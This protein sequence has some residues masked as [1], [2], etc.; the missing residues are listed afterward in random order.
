MNVR[1]AVNVLG[2]SSEACRSATAAG[3]RWQ[4]RAA[5]LGVAACVLLALVCG[6]C[7]GSTRTTR[8]G[9]SAADFN[10]QVLKAE[11]PILVQFSKDGCVACW[12]MDG[13]V[14][15]LAQEYEGR[16]TMASFRAYNFLFGIPCKEIN[17]RYNIGAVP[18]VILF[19]N[20]QEKKRWV[21]EHNG[22]KYRPV[23]DQYAGPV[24]TPKEVRAAPRGA[25]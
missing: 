17:R 13:L 3:R 22:D 19:I 6:G 11:K 9:E 25:G 4:G 1:P 15:Q 2:A 16:V 5:G 12:A 23:L 24:P 18:T 14:D 20:G 8:V 10:Q 7:G 21:G